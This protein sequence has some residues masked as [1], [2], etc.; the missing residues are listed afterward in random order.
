MVVTDWKTVER[1]KRLIEF[2]DRTVSD[3][4]RDQALNALDEHL[5]RKVA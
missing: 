1:F 4:F 5:G 3:N 2:T